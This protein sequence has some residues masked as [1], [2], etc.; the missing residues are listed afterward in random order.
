MSKPRVRVAFFFY[1]YLS[2]DP[3]CGCLEVGHEGFEILPPELRK[4]LLAREV[5]AGDVGGHDGRVVRAVRVVQ[6][7]PGVL[8]QVRTVHQTNL[9]LKAKRKKT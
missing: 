2:K 1:S 5:T 7:R 4:L 6:Q 9:Q 3:L 8:A